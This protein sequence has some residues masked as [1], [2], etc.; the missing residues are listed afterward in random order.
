M[1]MLVLKIAKLL[2]K[3]GECLLKLIYGSK[4]ME[5]R[6]YKDKS[7]KGPI[8]LLSLMAYFWLPAIAAGI[9]YFIIPSEVTLIAGA[10]ALVIPAVIIIWTVIARL[11]A[12]KQ[13]PIMQE[14]R[15]IAREKKAAEDKKKRL[16]QL[17]QIEKA[18]AAR[19]A[20][21]ASTAH[22]YL[23]ADDNAEQ[24]D[25]NEKDL[26]YQQ[27]TAQAG[28]YCRKCGRYIEPGGTFRCP[29]CGSSDIM[30]I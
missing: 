8:L 7:N 29:D 22:S 30:Y 6:Q 21:K 5:I 11:N 19:E 28:G 25:D 14:K 24:A 20:R 12:N 2:I 1:S 15:R 27:Q 9:A 23:T 26:S 10:L 16:E 3:L 4:G 17:E 18:K 13:Y